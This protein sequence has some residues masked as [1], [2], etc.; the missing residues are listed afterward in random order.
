MEEG[1]TPPASSHTNRVWDEAG[2]HKHLTG[3]RYLVGLLVIFVCSYFQ[4]IVS[5]ISLVAGAFCVYGIS[6]AVIAPLYG[7]SI[8]RKAFRNTRIALRVGLGFFGVFTLVGTGASIVIVAILLDLDP[9]ALKLLQ[10]PVPV[11]HVPSELAWIMV[12]ASLLVIGPC[13]EFLFRGFVFGGLLS[14]FGVRHWLILAVLSSV[15]FA[16]VHLYYALTYHIA[17]L[18]P[19][20]DIVAIGMA[21]AITYYLSGGNLLIPAL[22]HGVYDATG[23]MAAAV[24]PQAGWQLR[25]MLILIGIIAAVMM[26]RRR[27]RRRTPPTE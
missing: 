26:V 27:L 24:S 6:I 20:V 7:G 14:L 16:A 1:L 4:Y 5:G 23:F 17:S 11:L 13:E 25:G 8:L 19:F 3:K 18:V 12:W 21:F 10:R 2:S 15:L 9:T 22:I